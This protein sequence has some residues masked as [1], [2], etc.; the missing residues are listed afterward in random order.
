MDI[1]QL[2]KDI[3]TAQWSDK[4][5]TEIISNLANPNSEPQWS[6]DDQQ[7]LCY[8]NRIWILNTNDL[9]LWIL[10]NKH[11]YLISGHYGQNKTMELVRRDYTWPNAQGLLQVLYDLCKIQDSKT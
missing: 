9:Q 11:A 5:C 2:H 1:D 6:L 8:D 3:Y 10:I 4:C 7:L